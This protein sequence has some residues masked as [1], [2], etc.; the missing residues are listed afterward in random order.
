MHHIAQKICF[1]RT[2][3]FSPWGWCVIIVLVAIISIIADLLL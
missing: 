1:L 3:Y 2:P